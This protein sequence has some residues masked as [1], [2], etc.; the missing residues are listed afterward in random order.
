[1]NNLQWQVIAECEAKNNGIDEK[2][3]RVIA[4]FEYPSHAEDF[5]NMCLPKENKSKFRIERI[6]A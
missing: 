1:M 5:I 6:K 2:F 3:D 4:A